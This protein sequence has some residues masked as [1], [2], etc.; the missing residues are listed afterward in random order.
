MIESDVPFRR[1]RK[2]PGDLVKVLEIRLLISNDED[3]NV[4]R[5]VQEVITEQEVFFSVALECNLTV[6]PA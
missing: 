6:K 2:C 3:T 1:V 4:T 5:R